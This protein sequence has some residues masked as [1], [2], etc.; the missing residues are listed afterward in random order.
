MTGEELGGT[1]RPGLKCAIPRCS[2]TSRCLHHARRRQ[3]ERRRAL[4]AAE[5]AAS[6]GRL[7][8][9]DPFGEPRAARSAADPGSP[10]LAR[11]LVPGKDEAWA[12]EHT[13]SQLLQH[14]S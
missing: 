6:S 9:F 2:D 12:N 13:F 10:R 11:R 1:L 4:S 3:Q 14:G 5:R 7:I 8:S